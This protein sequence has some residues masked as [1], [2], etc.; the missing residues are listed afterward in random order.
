ML[1]CFHWKNQ[2]SLIHGHLPMGRSHFQMSAYDALMEAFKKLKESLLMRT[3]DV[4]SLAP[5]L[6]LYTLTLI[7]IFLLCI[8]HFLCEDV[9]PATEKVRCEKKS[10]HLCELLL[11]V[12]NKFYTLIFG[13]EDNIFPE[14]TLIHELRLLHSFSSAYKLDLLL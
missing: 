14:Q 9:K 8:Q 11:L 3:A 1:A 12:N 4:F 7:S 6:S 13:G 10:L 2:S 5:R